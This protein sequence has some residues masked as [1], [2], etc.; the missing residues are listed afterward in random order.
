MPSLEGS[1]RAESLGDG[2]PNVLDGLVQRARCWSAPETPVDDSVLLAPDSSTVSAPAVLLMSSDSHGTPV[3]MGSVCDSIHLLNYESFF[4]NHFNY[5]DC[6]RS[7]SFIPFG[8]L[9]QHHSGFGFGSFVGCSTIT[10]TVYPVHLF[11]YGTFPIHV[12][13]PGATMDLSVIGFDFS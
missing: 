10:F 5:S 8:T 6:K 11:R 13:I 9:T 1:N 12:S 7:R 3:I 4:H 2:R